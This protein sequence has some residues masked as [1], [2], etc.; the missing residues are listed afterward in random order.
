MLSI[1]ELPRQ[2]LDVTEC[3]R[4]LATATLGRL[5]YTQ[6][7]LPAVQP[8]SYAVADGAVVMP[9]VPGSAAVAAVRGAIVVLTVDSFGAD[10]ADGWAVTVVGP[11]RVVDGCVL[12]LPGLVTGWRRTPP[13]DPRGRPR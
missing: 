4:L 13:D 10:P 9:A 11:A 7:A 3:M 6:A 1:G 2:E 12:L 5:G 8:V